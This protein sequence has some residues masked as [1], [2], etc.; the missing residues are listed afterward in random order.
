MEKILEGTLTF[1]NFFD[2]KGTTSRFTGEFDGR[3]Y[4]TQGLSDVIESAIG[5]LQLGRTDLVFRARV[6]VEL[7]GQAP[8]DWG[9][10]L[11]NPLND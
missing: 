4:D 6:T 10:F 2:P 3:H 11:K 5:L 9:T 8:D 7:E 1:S